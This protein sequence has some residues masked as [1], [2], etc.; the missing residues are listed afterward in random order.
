M[1]EMMQQ[2]CFLLWL[3]GGFLLGTASEQPSVKNKMPVQDTLLKADVPIVMPTSGSTC[4]FDNA[5]SSL[6][7]GL[8]IVSRKFEV[9]NDSLLR[10]RWTV[11]D[12]LAEDM[13]LARVCPKF[14]KPDYGIMHFVCTGTTEKSYRILVNYKAIKYLP[15]T[16][17]YRFHT[18]ESYLLQSYGVRRRQEGSIL[19]LRKMPDD[20]ADTLAIP[21]GQELFCPVQVQGDWLQVK[22]DCFYNETDHPHEGE[23]CREYIG[24][25]ET[26]LT[27]WLRWR[28]DQHLLIDIF[29]MP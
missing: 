3:I 2:R 11:G 13:A 29:L 4:T 15:K 23:P 8:V 7:I 9:F 22:Y 16:S 24:E 19:P 14:F 27:G 1:N 26:P 21:A 20:H 28:S 6:G 17:A 25:C 18:W 12:M 10:E 5:V